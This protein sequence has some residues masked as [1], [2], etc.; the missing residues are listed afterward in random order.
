MSYARIESILDERPDD[1]D[2]SC[3]ACGCVIPQ[4]EAKRVNAK[5]FCAE[6]APAARHYAALCAKN[7]G[8]R[9]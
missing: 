6:H 3:A 7:D 4:D 1:T 2:V 5:W 9:A 8:A